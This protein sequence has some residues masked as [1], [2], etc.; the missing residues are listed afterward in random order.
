MRHLARRLRQV[1]GM[2]SER[3]VQ[4]PSTRRLDVAHAPHD[5]CWS[6]LPL[7]RCRQSFEQSTRRRY[8]R[9]DSRW[10]FS[11]SIDSSLPHLT[12]VLSQTL[13]LIGVL[14]SQTLMNISLRTCMLLLSASLASVRSMKECWRLRKATVRPVPQRWLYLHAIMEI[15]FEDCGIASYRRLDQYI[16]YTI[17]LI[18][19]RW[20]AITIT[21]LKDKSVWLEWFQ[22]YSRQ[23]PLHEDY[24]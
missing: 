18:I 24:Q 16:H 9:S 10:F 3:R 20:P 14:Q 1:T 15:P 21:V 2:S 6:F 12:S 17:A 4:S 13:S 22:K 11:A 5:R 7:C 23:F 8:S 19:S